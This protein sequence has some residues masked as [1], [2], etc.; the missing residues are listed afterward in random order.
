MDGSNGSHE[1]DSQHDRRQELLH[2]K[3]NN[4]SVVQIGKSFNACDLKHFCSHTLKSGEEKKC[5]THD[6]C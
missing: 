2:Q 3:R 5:E 6:K 4:C 1:D